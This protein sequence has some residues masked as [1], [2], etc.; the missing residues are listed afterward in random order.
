MASAAPESS[1]RASGDPTGL[2]IAAIDIGTNSIHMVIARATRAASFEVVDREREVVQIGRGSF[3]DGRLRVDAMRRT[4]AALTRYTELARRRQVDRILC[5][6]TAAVREARN[7]GDFLRAAREAS[8]VRPRVIPA[9]EEARLTWLGA[10]GAVLLDERPT[11]FVDLGGGSL[12]LAV[13][14]RDRL[15]GTASARLGALRLT[16]TMLESDPPSRSELQA[17]RRHIRREAGRVLERVA[18]LRPVRLI[19]CSG[20]I[21]ALAQAAHEIETG[22]PVGQLNGHVLTTGS[23]ARLTRRLQGVDRPER[24]ALPGIDATRAEIIV[25][26]ALVLLHILETLEA[27]GIT[28]SDAGVREGLVSDYLASHARE[29][30]EVGAVENLRL[31][32]VVGLLGKFLPDPRHSQQVARL[33]LALFDALRRVHGLGAHERELLHYAGLLHDVGAVVGYDRHGEHSEYLIRNGAL[34]GLSASEI[35]IIASVA[36]YHGAAK[37]K[38]R[39][40]R[41]RELAKAE[42]R[43]VRWL[44]ALLRVAEG[45]DRT[46]YQLVRGLRVVRTPERISIFVDARGDARLELWAARRRG[47]L[48]EERSGA[49]V[50]ISRERVVEGRTPRLQKLPGERA[51][52][53]PGPAKAARGEVPPHPSTHP[54]AIPIEGMRPGI[55]RT[56]R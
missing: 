37:P 6:A 38:K 35:A 16:E 45:L 2:R 21:H 48:L 17:L 1:P 7:G 46:H 51:P 3:R 32:S 41:F 25:P 44:A 54:A 23:L 55:G 18:A 10:R 14:N 27:P 11:L 13:G 24:E 9:D 43:T 4:I 26:G 28:M 53:S 34:R 20:A 22:E 29:V 31:R 8:G 47:G 33:A 12:Q 52:V 36:R 30:T 50:R 39:D 42:R 15:L 56:P 40:E 19:G 5:T 49:R